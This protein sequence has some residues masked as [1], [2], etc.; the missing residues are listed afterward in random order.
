MKNCIKCNAEIEDDGKFCPKC[1]ASQETQQELQA[2][3]QENLALRRCKGCGEE[4]ASDLVFCPKCGVRQN[5]TTDRKESIDKMIAN[6]ASVTDDVSSVVSDAYSLVK[7]GKKV[8]KSATKVAGQSLVNA[9]EKTSQKREEEN[10]RIEFIKNFTFSN[11]PLEIQEQLTQMYEV[12]KQLSTFSG[13]YKKMA[14]R[15]MEAAI[16]ILKKNKCKKEAKEW[17][18]MIETPSQK[19]GRI[20]KTI[21]LIVIILLVLY[22]IV[23]TASAIGTLGKFTG[24]MNNQSQTSSDNTGDN[25]KNEFDEDEL[26][27]EIIKSAINDLL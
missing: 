18:K 2:Q 23:Q 1:G 19:F 16:V 13:T 12:Q 17:K 3:K 21:I 4:I 6:A 10:E 15:K 11:D 27:N 7:F 14:Q 24:S 26:V 25:T 22:G 20:I 9:Q 5:S 8:G